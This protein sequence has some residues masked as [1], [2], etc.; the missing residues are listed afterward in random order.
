MCFFH[1]IRIVLVV[2]TVLATVSAAFGSAAF[3]S[4]EGGQYA[5]TL[6][7][8]G[9]QVQPS[10]VI[11]PAG[12]YVA[13]QDNI[14]DGDDLGISALILDQSYSTS[15]APIQVNES[16]E[17]AQENVE[18]ALLANG[19]AAFVW[20][21]GLQGFQ[22]IFARMIGPDGTFVG[23]EIKV[24]EDAGGTKSTPTL[25]VLSDGNVVVAWASMAQDGSMNGVYARR[26]SPAGELLDSE[27]RLNETTLY[28]Q[29]NPALLAL[30]DGGFLAAW[31]G[32]VFRGVANAE[33]QDGR[34]S[35]VSGA[36]G[37]QFD[38]HLFAR[39]YSAA[40]AP[41]SGEMQLTESPVIAANPRLIE[42][43]SGGFG[44]A[45]SWRDL[46][47][48]NHGWDVAYLSCN[49]AGER[50]S[51][52]VLLNAE[53]NGHQIAPQ[54]AAIGGRIVA[55]W[56][57]GG[58]DGSRAG[59]YGRVI[60]DAGDFAG[61]EFRVNSVVEANQIHPVLASD[62]NRRA[63]VVWSSYVGPY[64]FDLFGQRFLSSEEPLLQ[65][66][67]P[68]A[69]ALSPVQIAVSWP[70]VAGFE[71][72]HFELYV[73]GAKEPIT[74]ADNQYVH[75]PVAPDSSHTYRL[76]YR[77]VDGRV[78]PL[79][80]PTTGVSWGADLNFDGLPD[81]W[82]AQWGEDRSL[83][84]DAKEDSDGDGASNLQEFLSGTD[85]RDA[86]SVLRVRIEPQGS[87]FWFHWNTEPG[88]IYQVQAS[89]D[90][91]QWEAYGE[92]RFAPDFT[93]AIQIGGGG[94]V[95]YFRIVKFRDHFRP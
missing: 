33:D 34:V 27:F 38:A 68:Y 74:V 29:Q 21:G 70:W 48:V 93:D 85:P 92:P 71:V 18:V 88:G 72:E 12:G 9:E 15:L 91:E 83:W 44:V 84:P 49:L 32:E 28:N 90:L 47:D 51:E 42:L 1:R 6:R 43:T 56:T 3:L 78:S 37:L 46:V 79:S 61:D 24:N 57:S 17:G 39:R 5:L 11:G 89:P 10:A 76:A 16:E 55:V 58:Q 60:G 4:P 53:R 95:S 63:L 41:L 14:T 82:Q 64:S 80:E 31:S 2:G 25:C 65:P 81:N 8:L 23:S 20:Q 73:D 75:Q 45:A 30:A 59:I 35:T 7:Y 54:L 19:G 40:G 62:G 52:P 50:L 69:N 94:A 77:L 26:L 67:P 22:D 86:E 36:G 13:W 87:G 66:A